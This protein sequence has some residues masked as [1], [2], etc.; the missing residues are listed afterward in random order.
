[1]DESRWYENE[2]FWTVMAPV[3]FSSRRWA[4]VEDVCAAVE[5]MALARALSPLGGQEARALSL[6]PSPGFEALS[7]SPRDGPRE[8]ALSPVGGAS[9]RALSPGEAKRGRL[10]DALCALGRTSLEFARR[11]WTVTG[12]D[13]CAPY[14]RAAREDAAGRGLAVDFIQ[15]DI[16]G[17]HGD[18]G[19]DMAVNLYNSFGYLESPEDDL[20]MLRALHGALKPG[21]TLVMEFQGRELVLRDFRESEWYEEDGDIVLLRS[22][23]EE[24]ATKLRQEWGLITTDGKRHRF[25]FVQRLYGEDDLRAILAQAGFRRVEVFGNLRGAAYGPGADSLVAVARKA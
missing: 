25:P 23:L 5:E 8:R 24:G 3:M 14:L 22:E 16:R 12:V 18:G 7:P 21:G 15:A 17:F 4:E 10:L 6:H 19:F 2:D 9:D 11:G 1:M 20:A 13:L